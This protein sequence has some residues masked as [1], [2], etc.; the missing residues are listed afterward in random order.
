MSTKRVIKV[1]AYSNVQEEYVAGAATI[2]PGML[3]A[4]ASTGKVSPHAT[5]GVET[6]P[7]FALEDDLQGKTIDDLYANDAP[8]QCWIPYRGDMVYAILAANETVVIGD[9]LSSQ[10]DGTFVKQTTSSGVTTVGILQ[11]VEA[12]DLTASGAVASRII[13][14]VL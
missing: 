2:K 7:L 9:V 10:G 5:A 12:L 14:R 4:L 6:L 13:A 3:L 11:A 1:K 8:V